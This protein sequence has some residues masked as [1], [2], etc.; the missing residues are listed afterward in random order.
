VIH[1]AREMNI[2]LCGPTIPW[3]GIGM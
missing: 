1:L 3:T 2:I